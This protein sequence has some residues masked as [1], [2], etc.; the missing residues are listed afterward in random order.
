MAKKAENLPTVQSPRYV[1]LA[2]GGNTAAIIAA[3]L[4]GEKVGVNDL[5]RIK[6]PSGGGLFLELPTLE[7]SEMVKEIEGIL[8]YSAQGRGYWSNP[9][10]TGNPPECWSPN[11]IIGNGDPGGKC[12]TCPLA[13]FGSA[14]RG[15]GQACKEVRNLFL[16]LPDRAL[17]V[18]LKVPPTS[19]KAI[20]KYL[21]RL[22]SFGVIYW[23]TK[24]KITL[25]ATKNAEGTAYAEVVPVKGDSLSDDECA[26]VDEYRSNFLPMLEKTAA[27]MAAAAE[28]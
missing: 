4:D 19:I 11:A 20:K 14:K 1:A 7:G 12:A 17:P 18:V 24:I 27:A 22:A 25:N 13:A 15:N 28:L 26:A 3:N 16:L 8:I 21:M 10:V 5:E 23:N 2:G 6:I 9:D